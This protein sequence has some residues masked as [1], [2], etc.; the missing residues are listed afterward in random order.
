M[1]LVPFLRYSALN[2]GVTLIWFW[3]RSRSLKMA[4]FDRSYTTYYWSAIVNIALSC[5]IFEFFTFNNI[6]TLKSGLEITRSLEMAPLE[7]FGMVSYLHFVA[8]IMA[9]SLAVCEILSVK[10]WRD[11]E[12]LVR[13]CSR[14]LKMAPFDRPYTTFYWSAIVSIVYHFRVIWR[15]VISWPW[16]LG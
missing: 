1:Y 2:N 4:P 3:G 13:G 6:V 7:S 14:S 12:N 15:W 10:E 8:T 9:V 16:N 5:T 11:L